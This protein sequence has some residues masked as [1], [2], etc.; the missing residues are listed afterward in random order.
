MLVFSLDGSA[1]LP[2]F[3]ST[4]APRNLATGPLNP[5]KIARGETVFGQNCARC[6]GAATYSVGVLPDLKR[7]GLLGD[8]AAWKSVVI[9]GVLKDRGMVS[10]A[11]YISSDD[12]ES[13]RQYVA[14]QAK[15]VP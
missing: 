4:V 15:T 14:N 6:H 7:S 10:F 5:L 11:K 12:A 3:T 13:A 9:D 1:T 2:A 8:S